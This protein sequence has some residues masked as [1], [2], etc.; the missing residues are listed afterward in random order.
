MPDAGRDGHAGRHAPA[1]PCQ[2]HGVVDGVRFRHVA[3]DVVR[4]CDVPGD[5]R[6]ALSPVGGGQGG[7]DAR[8]A[9]DDQCE[10][11]GF[12]AHAP[13][14]A[15]T[16]RDR[17]RPAVTDSW[18]HPCSEAR[19]RRSTRRPCRCRT[20]R[21]R[22][23][24][25]GRAA[26]GWLSDSSSRGRRDFVLFEASDGVG[27]TWRT[28]TYPGA[29][30]DV[31]SHLY[32]Y[33]FALKPDWTKTY[34]AQPEI[35]QYFEDCA[36]RFGIRPHLRPNTRITRRTLGR[37]Q[38]AVVP[39]RRRRAPPTKPTC[40]S[41]PS[42]RSRR[43]SLPDIEGLAYLHRPLLPL[44]A[45]GARARPDGR[46][47]AVIG[48]GA[49]AAQIVPEVAK[50]ARAGL[51]LPTHA[52]MDPAAVGQAVH[53]EA[54]AAVRPQSASSMR[55]HRRGDLLGLREHDRL[56]PRRGGGRAAQGDR[57]QPHRLPDQGRRAAGQAHPGLPV[58]LQAHAGLQRLLQGAAARQRRAGHRA[59]RAG[60]GRLH[61]HRR[62]AATA[63][64]RHRAGDRVP[65]DRVPGGHRGRR[66]SDGRRLH[67]DW[68]EVA[69][70]Y[71]GLTVSGYPNFFMLYG[72]NTNQG[73]NSIIV[74]LEAQ[75]AYVL[76]ALRAMRRHRA[77]AVDVR[78]DV[79]EA[80]NRELA[81]GA[82]GDRVE[83][84]LPELL[85]ERQRQD[86]HPAAPDLPVV[87]R[88]GR[89][90]SGCGS[91]SGHEGSGV[92]RDRG[93][94]RVPLRGRARPRARTGRHPD[95][96]RGGQH[97]GRR[98]AQPAGRRPGPA[99]RTSSGYQCAGTVAEVGADVRGFAVGD[100]VVTVGLDG[101]HAERR[102]VPE[103]VRLEDP[104]R[105]L[106]RRGGLRAGPVRHGRRLPL[107][108][109]PP[110]GGRDGADPCRRG[111]CR[112]RGHPDGEAGRRARLRHRLERRPPRAAARSSASTRASTTPPTTSSPRRVG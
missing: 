39:H 93:A 53:R 37:R 83:R 88:A 84:R 98:H 15:L 19:W 101:S 94:R 54:E 4:A 81:R 34:A 42:A 72:P 100:R 73:G 103:G 89:R 2:A 7:A 65:G 110:A 3:G 6:R 102:A 40:W 46:R 71:L 80:Y 33:S 57:A 17:T 30:C 52:P 86:R 38:A 67:D 55:R 5:G 25:R 24:V 106:D 59:H 14:F 61:R 16:G 104:R 47:V 11:F 91:M 97:R 18:L 66:A 45:L 44:G 41:A 26:S 8:P 62:R 13:P 63:G 105:R 108:V 27:G 20:G 12:V 87:R 36:D 79:M 23:S 1:R 70:A 74:I 111:R 82:G 43:P 50:S 64:R 90:A 112:H 75:A 109:R 96:R 48:T 49:S 51:R 68:S 60:H 76:G 78:R 95:R 99:C 21:L 22:S 69:H 85:Q 31:P 77:R 56:P 35:L 10:R 28:N 92:L 29:A 58:R 9:P 107:R 32:S